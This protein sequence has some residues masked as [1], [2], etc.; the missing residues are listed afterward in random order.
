LTL[1]DSICARAAKAEAFT[2]PAARMSS[3]LATSASHGWPSHG[4]WYPTTLTEAGSDPHQACLTWL[5]CAFRVSHPLDALFRLQPLRPC[6][7]PVTPLGLHSQRVPLSGSGRTSRRD[8]PPL[9]F[10]RGSPLPSARMT[11]KRTDDYEGLRIRR[12]RSQ[13]GGVTRDPLAVPL[14]VLTSSRSPIG[15]GSVLPRSLLSWAF[16]RR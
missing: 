15:L 7:M 5:C 1:V 2:T 10:P 11:T 12:V 6:F 9:P 13:Q 8:L 3:R 16:T 14:P 4:V